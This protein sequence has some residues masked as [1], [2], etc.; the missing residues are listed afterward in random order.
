MSVFKI[1]DY[2]VTRILGQGGMGKVFQAISPQGA[3]VAI[4]TMILAEGLDARTRWETVERFQREARAARSLVHPNIVQVVDIGADQETFF[5]VMEF[6]DGQSIRELVGLA[7]A[8]KVD[9]AVEIM[10]SACEALSYAHGQGVVH[11]DIKPDNIM[12]LRNGTVKITDFGLAAIIT[13]KGLTQTGTIMGTLAYMSPEQAR[14]EKLDV[15]SDIF[16]LGAT[17]WE[18][19][20]G[21]QLYQG[22]TAVVLTRILNEDPP[23][24]PSLP[25]HVSRTVN[26]CLR[27]RPEHRYQ[28]VREMIESLRMAAATDVPGTTLQRPGTQVSAPAPPGAPPGTQVS[29]PAAGATP[30]STQVSRPAATTTFRC[31]KCR[32]PM[33][34]TAASCWKCGTPNPLLK[35]RTQQQKSQQEILDALRGSQPPKKSGWWKKK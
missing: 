10:L 2:T 16:S 21:K 3:T 24:I 17:F 7:G 28:T 11:R 29:H 8:L 27:K 20:S 32:E 1:G 6:L 14:G 31:G 34:Q 25:P 30:P 22:E 26:R 35:Q 4:K 5:I 19:L 18:M 23:S 33:S 9:R 15:R 12:V 13:E